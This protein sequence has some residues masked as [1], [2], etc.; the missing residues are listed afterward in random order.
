M[1]VLA[2]QGHPEAGSLG[3]ALAEA[4]ADGARSAGH[5]VRELRIRELDFDPV[6]HDRSNRFEDA[7]AD[8]QSARES[9]LWAEHLI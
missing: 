3:T 8:I 9:I 4:Y 2:I 1:K 6:L 7:E 5:E